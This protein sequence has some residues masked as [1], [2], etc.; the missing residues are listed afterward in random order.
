VLPARRPRS[1]APEWR[2][3]PTRQRPA[4]APS[5]QPRPQ[6]TPLE[7][8]R[9]AC[10]QASLRIALVPQPA[11]ALQHAPAAGE[12]C[13]RRRQ[14]HV[15]S[16]SSVAPAS[17]QRAQ[18]GASP[19]PCSFG[20]ATR[21]PGLASLPFGLFALGHALF[22]PCSIRHQSVAGRW[23]LDQGCHRRHSVRRHHMQSQQQQ[24]QTVNVIAMGRW[25]GG[26]RGGSWAERS[27][28]PAVEVQ[29]DGM[30]RQ[31]SPLCCEALS[32]DSPADGLDRG[33]DHPRAASVVLAA[34]RACW[35]AS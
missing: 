33:P 1:H 34:W 21:I 8:A 32:L 27:G 13:R 5:D 10:P 15:R 26:L 12:P 3:R 31:I 11:A 20:P 25:P 35:S 14:G 9:S 28:R 22:S 7:P 29:G 30:L 4:S 2:F 16:A 19:L 23:A 6:S 17:R 18:R 24:Q